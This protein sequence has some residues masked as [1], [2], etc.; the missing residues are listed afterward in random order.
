MVSRFLSEPQTQLNTWNDPTIPHY[1]AAYLFIAYLY[2]RFGEEAI[3]AL[4][5]EQEN[6]LRS[7]DTIL[8]DYSAI[9][10]DEFF[11]DW[12][13][14]NYLQ[15]PELAEGQYGYTSFEMA[16]VPT[17]TPVQQYPYRQ[18]VTSNQY[19]TNYYRLNNLQDAESLRIQIQMSATADLLPTIAISGEKFWY[20]NRGD[21]SDTTLTKAFDLRGVESATLSY[22]TWYDLEEFWDYA[23]LMIS[24]DQG[25]TWEIIS[26]NFMTD[27]NPNN[28]AYGVGYTGNLE[29][30]N[31]GREFVNLDAYAGQEILVRFEVITDD[32]VNNHGFAI[33]DIWLIGPE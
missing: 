29:Q 26:A 17:N 12:V 32:A 23:Y 7:V 2:E 22:W 25:A 11:A 33:D 6:G 21:E 16:N 1:G 28:T 4:S 9:R 14:A 20:S 31:W 24:T 19:A 13:L 10:I 3:R 15:N 5:L 27:H 30:G 18:E 8:K